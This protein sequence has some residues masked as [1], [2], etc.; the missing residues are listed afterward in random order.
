MLK[1]KDRYVADMVFPFVA[2]L[3]KEVFDLRRILT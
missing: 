2:L 3:L 1:G